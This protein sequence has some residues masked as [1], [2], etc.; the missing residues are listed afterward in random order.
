MKK[1]YIETRQGQVHYR[2]DG[3]TG[4]YLFLLHLTPFSSRMFELALPRLGRHCRAIA[5]DT[6]GYGNSDPPPAPIS[7]ADYGERMLEAID[8][9]TSGPFALCGFSTGAA[10]ALEIARRVSART[11][12]LILST[13]PVMTKDE[14]KALV[15]ANIGEPEMAP[16]GSH[17]LRAWR[18]R[19]GVW[20]A[21]FDIRFLHLATADIANVYDRYHWGLIAVASCNVH[22]LLAEARCPAL[23]LS[24]GNDTHAHYNES[25]AAMVAGARFELIPGAS[26]PICLTAPEDFADNVARFVLGRA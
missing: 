13:T 4:P 19:Q 9:I 21:D 24:G 6:P 10:I 1:G 18:G 8:R 7:I 12:R 20:G 14:L 17:F 25:A 15:T 16:D 26:A 11:D 2:A 23:F 3:E 5:L 22:A